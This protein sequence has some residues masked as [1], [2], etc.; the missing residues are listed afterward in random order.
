MNQTFIS[1]IS[2]LEMPAKWKV[3]QSG[4]PGSSVL[5][6]FIL[7]TMLGWLSLGQPVS[8]EETTQEEFPDRL[9]LYGGYQLL[10]GLDATIRL[11]GSNTGFGST[12]DLVDDFGLDDNDH[13]LRAGARF[14]F[15][16]NHA[17]A[18]AWYDIS[19]SGDKSIDDSLQ[20]DDEIFQV[21]ARVQSKV[22]LTLYRLYYNWSFYR[23]AKT[24]LVLS[25]GMYFGDF[26]AKF[27]GSAVVDAGNILQASRSSTVKES[28]FAPLPT[29][30][31]GAIYKIF[32][33]LT[34]HARTDFFY[35]S[36]DDIE[37]TIAEFYFGLEY[38]VFKHFA[39]GAA[40]DRIML[41]LEYKSGKP[42]GWELNAAWNSGIFYGA[43]YF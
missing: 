8:A 9:K 27:K 18:F 37:G 20:I 13:M 32:P 29:V 14:R 35:V 7:L 5:R 11:D 38:R 16:E 24:E 26:D 21:G 34:A 4:R 2:G 36:I 43:L 42:K 19:L 6:A 30:G 40:Y 39:I 25:P 1:F 31:V 41:D 22:D 15:N 23:S 12:V 33:R 3:R 10:F 17:I 28:L